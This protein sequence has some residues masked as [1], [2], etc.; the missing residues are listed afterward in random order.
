MFT[1]MIRKGRRPR[2][3]RRGTI[4]AKEWR[5]D[6]RQEGAGEDV[7]C[8]KLLKMSSAEFISQDRRLV[9][10]SLTKK[11]RSIESS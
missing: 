10:L 4:S 5:R 2:G 11:K 7:T 3:V 9:K 8:G 1:K 6:I